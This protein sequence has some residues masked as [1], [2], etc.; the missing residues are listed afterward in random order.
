MWRPNT[1]S[2]PLT[3]SALLALG[4]AGL[5]ILAERRAIEREDVDLISD[6]VRDEGP[7]AVRRDDDTARLACDGVLDADLECGGVEDRDGSA[8]AAGHDQRLLVRRQRQTDRIGSDAEALLDRQPRA[9]GT[10]AA[11]DD[12]L[13]GI[14]QRDEQPPVLPDHEL[15]RNAPQPRARELTTLVDVDHSNERIILVGDI[16]DGLSFDLGERDR[17]AV[18]RR[19][20][21][22]D[23][24]GR[25]SVRGRRHAIARRAQRAGDAKR[26]YGR[27]AGMS[28]GRG[29][30]AGGGGRRATE[31]EKQKARPVKHR[32]EK[33]PARLPRFRARAIQLEPVRRDGRTS[34]SSSSTRLA[35]IARAMRVEWARGSSAGAG[36][37]AETTERVSSRSSSTWRASSRALVRVSASISSPARPVLAPL[38]DGCV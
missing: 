37:P 32:T 19:G 31:E 3:R 4:S 1:S 26:R 24:R 22:V 2:M 5:G 21:R 34:A 29:M 35:A 33:R 23:D 27:A 7:L 14:A 20:E 12:H 28:L 11:E 25:R 17:R 30:G 16:R 8:P 9:L 10:A 18:A 36:T 6:D 13:R 15:T 38:A